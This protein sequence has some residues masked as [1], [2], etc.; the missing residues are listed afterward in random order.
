[1]SARPTPAVG[2][3]NNESLTLLERARDRF[4]CVMMLGILHHLLLADQIPMADVAMLLA[5][6]T[7]RSSIVEWIPKSD[8]RYID[9]CRG[10]TNSISI[11][12]KICS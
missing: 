6:L 12:M 9:L 1:M 7:R 10:E 8:V 5:S 2:W 3:C 4:D 11:W